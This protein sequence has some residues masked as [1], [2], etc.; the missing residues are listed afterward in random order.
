MYIYF[1]SDYIY[2]PEWRSKAEAKNAAERVLSKPEYHS[3]E[4]ENDTEKA[5]CVLLDVSRGG[6]IKLIFVRYDENRRNVV[7]ENISKELSKR[8]ASSR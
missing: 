8:P 3:C 4:S 1:F 2:L 6:R 7:P 5:R